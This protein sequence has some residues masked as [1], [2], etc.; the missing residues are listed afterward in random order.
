MLFKIDDYC[1]AYDDVGEG[2]EVILIHGFPLS[3]RMWNPQVGSLVASGFRV[4]TLDLP[5]FGESDT[6]P[7]KSM[8]DYADI[9]AKF[10]DFLKIPRA[11]VGGMSMG[12]YVLLE[13]IARYSHRLD[14]VLLITTRASADDEQAKAKRD[15][16]IQS[17]QDG[18]RLTLTKSMT[19]ILFG[20]NHN[21]DLVAIVEECMNQASDQGLINALHAM[22][23]RID[24]YHTLRGIEIP[25]WVLTADEDIASPPSYSKSMEQELPHC[26]F[27]MI[28]GA[29][30]L[31][32]REKSEE[33]NRL[34]LDFLNNLFSF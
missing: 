33:F 16:M 6:M 17:I 24:R 21:P 25:C 22:K 32:N 31:V 28:E 5:G 14:A 30:H 10:M 20:K 18:Q 26:Q 12:G 9:L 3:K 4:L 2:Q 8:A 19:A 34:L 23:S 27:D 7:V 11:V 15:I 1:L 29:G 13:F